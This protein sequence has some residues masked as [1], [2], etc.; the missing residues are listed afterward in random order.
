M[1][2]DQTLQ[3]RGEREREGGQ[4]EERELCGGDGVIKQS[5]V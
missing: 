5:N 4:R 2:S 1:D 3:N